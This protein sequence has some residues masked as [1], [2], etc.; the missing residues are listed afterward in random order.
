MGITIHYGG[1][2]K[3]AELIDEV[4][5]ELTD[6]SRDMEWDYEVL[7]CDFDKPNTSKLVTEEEKH[8]ITGNLP[9]KGI[10]IAIHQDSEPLTF[11][12]D[13]KGELRAL[14][15]MVFPDIEKEDKTHFTSV[16]TQFAPIDVHITIIKLL[17]YL[18]KKYFKELKVFDEAGY[19]ETGDENFLKEK[20]KFLSDRIDAV[21]KIL[22]ESEAELNECKSV[23]EI[24]EKLEKIL[25]A[26]FNRNKPHM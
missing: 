22:S 1:K 23:E 20:M 8:K 18:K 25:K 17:K 13:S 5:K 12:F 9:L 6:I 4:C 10:H 2:L 11:Y 16:K 21:E 15:S 26:N 19:W 14:L 7:D 24:V 3:S